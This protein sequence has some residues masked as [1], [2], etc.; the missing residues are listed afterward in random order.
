MTTL[1]A[2]LVALPPIIVVLA[3]LAAMPWPTSQ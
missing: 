1:H 3:C 2:T